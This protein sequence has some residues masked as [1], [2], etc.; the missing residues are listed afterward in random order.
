MLS[1][2]QKFKIY[3]RDNMKLSVN[4]AKY[5]RIEYEEGFWTGKKILMINGVRLTKQKKN[6]FVLDSAEGAITCKIS[7]NMLTGAYATIDGEVI[8]LIAPLSWYEIA[9]TVFIPVFVIAWG[10]SPVLCSIFPI[11]GGAIGGAISGIAA[12]VNMILTRKITST[13]LKLLAWLGVF[14]ATIL[15]CFIAAIIFSVLLVSLM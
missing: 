12:C 8:P 11:I 15:T 5:G 9:L 3:R 1:I 4:H 10:S 13:P 7:G 14:V 2:C 6:V